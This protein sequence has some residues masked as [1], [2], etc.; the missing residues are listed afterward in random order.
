MLI[1]QEIHKDSSITTEHTVQQSTEKHY[2]E[3]VENKNDQGYTGMYS[4]NMPIYAF[5][6]IYQFLYR[7]AVTLIDLAPGEGHQ[8]CA[9]NV[10]FSNFHRQPPVNFLTADT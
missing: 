8:A 2:L 6:F 5:T 3:R 7:L 4:Q 10:Y 9:L 1:F